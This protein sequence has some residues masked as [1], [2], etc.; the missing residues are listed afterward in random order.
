M[1]MDNTIVLTLVCFTLFIGTHDVNGQKATIALSGTFTT[2]EIP[3]NAKVYLVPSKK[4]AVVVYGIDIDTLN[5][6]VVDKVL[7][8]SSTEEIRSGHI[9]IYYSSKKLMNFP[10]EQEPTFPEIIKV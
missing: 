7:L 3:A 9:L 10:T 4:N 6:Q 1:V 2:A 8:I 5:I